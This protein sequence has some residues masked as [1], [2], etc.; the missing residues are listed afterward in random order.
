M[1]ISVLG[2]GSFGSALA[3]VMTKRGHEVLLWGRDRDVLL[4]IEKK[5]SNSKYLPQVY[6]DVGKTSG[7]L[8]QVLAWP[9]IIIFALPCQALRDFLLNIAKDIPPQAY[10]VNTAKGF[11]LET[12][13]LPMNIFHD[14]LGRGIASRYVSLSGPT[15]AKELAEKQPS[16]MALA[17]Q[18]E[19]SGLKLQHDLSTR[20]LRQYRTDDV[21]GIEICGAIKN[22]MA[23]GTGIAEGLGFGLNTRAGLITRCL[24]EMTKLG[25]AMGAHPQTFSGLAGI[26]DLILTCT[27]GL[28]RNRHVGVEIGQ[29]KKLKDILARM[30]NVAEG[31]YTAQ[32]VLYLSEK[33]RVDMP[34][35]TYVYRMLHEDLPPK[36]AL[37]EILSRELKKERE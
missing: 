25:V 14:V 15:F 22:V 29:G 6:L 5:H 32:S 30:N 36:E 11:E 8:T 34:N 28:S 10:L 7:D 1:K 16:G 23:I 17:C 18:S 12:H 21:L 35:A 19:A 20:F 26:G 24:H 13:A 9:E 31:V 2:A 27:G 33:Y 3:H 4:E 37:D